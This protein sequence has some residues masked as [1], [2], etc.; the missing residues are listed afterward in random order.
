MSVSEY[1]DYYKL[2]QIALNDKNNDKSLHLFQMY[3]FSV[4]VD[5]F[6]HS[7]NLFLSIPGKLFLVVFFSLVYKSPQCSLHQTQHRSHTFA[8][9]QQILQAAERSAEAFWQTDRQRICVHQA[10]VDWWWRGRRKTDRGKGDNN[11][12]NDRLQVFGFARQRL[13]WLL[14]LL[15]WSRQAA[16]FSHDR[17]KMKRRERK[18]FEKEWGSKSFSSRSSHCC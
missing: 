6:S 2:T 9:R 13:H 12:M 5:T 11:Q 14:C 17:K 4:I 18:M 16:A 1:V 15:V 3:H 8:V 10:D 7:L